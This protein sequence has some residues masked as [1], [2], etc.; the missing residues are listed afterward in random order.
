MTDQ[1]RADLRRGCGYALD[2]MPCITNGTI[3][4]RISSWT[5]GGKLR[6]L[7]KGN[8]KIIMDMMGRGQLYDLSVDPYE[9]N[10]LWD[11]AE[12]AVSKADM[13][14]FRRSRSSE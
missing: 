6:S 9:V 11:N 14:N 7:R 3:F 12:Y 13:L 8:L 10:D 4:A 2:T 1:H 5:S